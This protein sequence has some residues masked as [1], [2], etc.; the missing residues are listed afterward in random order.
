MNEIYEKTGIKVKIRCSAIPGTCH[1]LSRCVW[2]MATVPAI[3]ED[4][5]PEQTVLWGGAL[6]VGF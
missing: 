6:P 4:S 1:V 3:A 5:P 2:L